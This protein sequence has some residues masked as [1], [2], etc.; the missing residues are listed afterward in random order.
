LLEAQDGALNAAAKQF[1]ESK[2]DGEEVVDTEERS[3]VPVEVEQWD[4]V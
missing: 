3:N 4:G 1:K 2:A